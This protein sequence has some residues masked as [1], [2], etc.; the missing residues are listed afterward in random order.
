VARLR[1]LSTAQVERPASSGS[2]TSLR[3]HTRSSAAVGR[4]HTAHPDNPAARELAALAARGRPA[5]ASR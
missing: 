5:V 2:I 4:L 3:P 1:A